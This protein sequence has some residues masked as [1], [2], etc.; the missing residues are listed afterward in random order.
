MTGIPLGE[1]L[2]VEK[3]PAVVVSFGAQLSESVADDVATLQS[4]DVGV[5][6][7][8]DS[9]DGLKMG[10][11]VSIVLDG[12]AGSSMPGKVASIRS[13]SPQPSSDASS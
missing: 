11:A 2:F 8:L 12:D 13:D 4:Q 6:V 5:E 9:V 1:V 10:D 3:L 7:S